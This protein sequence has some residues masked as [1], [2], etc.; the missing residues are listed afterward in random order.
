[1]NFL[2]SSRLLSR[3]AIIT[4]CV[5]FFFFRI[6]PCTLCTILP[7]SMQNESHAPP[8]MVSTERIY[9]CRIA[10]YIQ[11]PV[12]GDVTVGSPPPDLG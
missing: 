5:P 2:D 11:E 12:Q 4:K 10:R 9:L 7:R 1:M 8:A 6:M 3:G